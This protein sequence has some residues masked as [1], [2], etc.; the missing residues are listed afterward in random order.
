M[1]SESQ[2]HPEPFLADMVQDP[3]ILAV[4]A[5]DGVTPEALLS[6]LVGMRERLR[7]TGALDRL[8]A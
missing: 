5:R 6:L 7:E 4:M 1:T 2:T 8:A 3:V